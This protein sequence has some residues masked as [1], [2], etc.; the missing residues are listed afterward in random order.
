MDWLESVDNLVMLENKEH[1]ESLDRPDLLDPMDPPVRLEPLVTQGLTAALV[2]LVP[3]DQ[4]ENVDL[5][6]PLEPQ[7]HAES[8]EREASFKPPLK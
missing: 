3:L 5:Q 7:E 2:L 1:E 8:L 6:D 4:Q